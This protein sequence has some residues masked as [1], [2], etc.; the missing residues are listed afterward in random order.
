MRKRG[1]SLMPKRMAVIDYADCQ[2]GICEKGICQAVLVCPRKLL[3]QE[4]PFEMP[5][6]Y[7]NMCLGCG[8][9]VQACPKKAVKMV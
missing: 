7:P 9:C 5:D 2:P 8:V 4:D 6:S 1:K 3:K